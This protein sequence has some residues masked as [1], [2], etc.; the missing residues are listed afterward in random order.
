MKNIWIVSIISGLIATVI[1]TIIGL[2]API[3]SLPKMIPAKMLSMMMG[4][5]LLIGW[6]MHFLIGVI[7]SMSFTLLQSKIF[8]RLSNSLIQGV[9]FGFAVFIFA[10][11]MMGFLSLII[12]PP[13]MQGTLI[14]NLTGS[15]IGHLI[16]GVTVVSINKKLVDEIT[17]RST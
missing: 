14:A 2:M 13:P 4:F 3:M 11:I 17:I 15:L 12:T 1:M 8:G 10:Q 6:M 5:P 9:L 7:F 16:Y